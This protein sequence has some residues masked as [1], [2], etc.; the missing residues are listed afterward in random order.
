M[1]FLSSS[2]FCCC[3][4]CSYCEGGAAASG[5]GAGG[6]GAG[7]GGGAGGA[8]AGG[9]GAGGAGGGVIG[10]ILPA[11]DQLVSIAMDPL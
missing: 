1:W 7:A 4:F 6:G 5:S 3:L 8:S 10:C 2:C 9:S 11:V